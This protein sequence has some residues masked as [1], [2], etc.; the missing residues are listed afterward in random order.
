[1]PLWYTNVC[2]C[3]HTY[4]YLYFPL[5]IY[6][7]QILFWYRH[8]QVCKIRAGIPDRMCTRS[9]TTGKESIGKDARIL[10]YLWMTRRR[11]SFFLFHRMAIHHRHMRTHL[12]DRSFQAVLAREVQ[13]VS[14][15]A[16]MVDVT[17]DPCLSHCLLSLCDGKSAKQQEICVESL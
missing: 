15:V 16:S 8:S 6:D 14:P 4:M 9:H 11:Q 2:P 10:V 7:A 1:M 5:M 17:R 3:E 13:E 12:L